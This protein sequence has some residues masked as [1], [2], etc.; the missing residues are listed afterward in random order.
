MYSFVCAS[1]RLRVCF[2]F[3]GSTSFFRYLNLKVSLKTCPFFI[4]TSHPEHLLEEP[5]DI[6][7]NRHFIRINK[8]ILE[9]FQIY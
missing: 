6:L 1:N 3:I 9:D 8:N 7:E 5:G 4:L 2:S